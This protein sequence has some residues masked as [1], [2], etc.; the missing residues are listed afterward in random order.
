[1][2]SVSPPSS[3]EHNEELPT[4]DLES[5]TTR[6]FPS[7]LERLAIGFREEEEGLGSPSGGAGIDLREVFDEGRI[8]GDA[9]DVRLVVAE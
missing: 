9:T 3:P 4:S 1:M 5:R 6:S 8:A 2:W 7:A